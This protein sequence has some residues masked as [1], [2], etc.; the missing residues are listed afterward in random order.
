MHKYFRGKSEEIFLNDKQKRGLNYD[1]LFNGSNDMSPLK[2]CKTPF[3]EYSKEKK[4]VIKWFHI[5][6]GH[7]DIIHL[8]LCKSYS[9]IFQKLNVVVLE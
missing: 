6:Q 2:L 5:F 4:Y 1:N 9:I 3:N 7:G 8:I